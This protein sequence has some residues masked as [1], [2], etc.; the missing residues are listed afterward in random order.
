MATTT[1]KFEFK[2][3]DYKADIHNGWCPGCGDFG[4]LT[5]IQTALMKLQRLPHKVAVVS[6]IGC[7][8]KTPHYMQ[9]YA[10]HTLHGRVMPSVTGLKLANPSLTVTG[11]GG[12]GDAY[13]IGAGHFVNGGPPN[14]ALTSGGSNNDAHAPPKALAR[15]CGYTF[16]ARGY[17]LDVKYLSE[18]IAQGIQHRGSTLIDVLQTC[19]TYNDL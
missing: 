4:I 8:G 14:P 1:T 19:P 2:I 3:K 12:D 15:A 6:G 18:L 9:T 17:A 7:S 16:V 5:A 10:F 13:G 11:V